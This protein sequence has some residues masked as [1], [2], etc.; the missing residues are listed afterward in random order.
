VDG[1]EEKWEFKLYQ[2]LT[3]DDQGFKG[4]DGARHGQIPSV[5][6]TIG[7]TSVDA[8]FMGERQNKESFTA[9]VARKNTN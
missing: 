4:T 7:P 3:G 9:Y 8:F 2:S 1:P 5:F 6:G